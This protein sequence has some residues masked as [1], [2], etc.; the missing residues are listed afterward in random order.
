MAFNP[1]LLEVLDYVFKLNQI[2]FG[3]SR[4]NYKNRKKIRSV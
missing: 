3:L 1:Q 2:T 4:I